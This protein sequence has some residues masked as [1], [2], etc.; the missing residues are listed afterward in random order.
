MALKLNQIDNGGTLISD[1]NIGSNTPLGYSDI[2][3][4]ENWN[5]YGA[6]LIGLFQS[7]KDWL[8]LRNEIQIL[9]LAKTGSDYSNWNNL[10]SN[11]KLIALMFLPTK[12]IDARG[13]TFYATE[14]GG[15]NIANAYLEEYQQA[16][17]QARIQRYTKMAFTAYG[18]LGKLQGIKAENYLRVASLD[19]LY[20]ERG[21]CRFSEDGIDGIVDWILSTSGTSYETTGLK[22]RIDNGEFTLPGGLTSTVFCNI[23]VSIIEEG[24]Y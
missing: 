11:E 8:A 18:Y 16:S 3:S 7:F 1:F 12:I 24:N 14:S 20:F 2:S 21:V 23:L 9:V 19:S 13:F 4:I 6:S 10:N 17:S 15:A 22:A 5:L